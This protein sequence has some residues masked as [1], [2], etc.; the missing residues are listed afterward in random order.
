ML[1][2]DP[3]AERG[4]GNRD[5]PR[6]RITRQSVR[7][8]AEKDSDDFT[9]RFISNVLAYIVEDVRLEVIPHIFKIPKKPLCMARRSRKRNTGASSGDRVPSLKML[10]LYPASS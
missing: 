1:S 4:H 3:V 8:V 2:E 5:T 7:S 9:S 6:S 10:A